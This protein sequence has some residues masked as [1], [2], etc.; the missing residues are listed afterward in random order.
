MRNTLLTTTALVLSAGIASA[1]GHASITWSGTGTAGLAREGS[2]AAVKLGVAKIGTDAQANKTVALGGAALTA[3]ASEVTDDATWAAMVL[4]DVA[5]DVDD[6]EDAM[7]TQGIA[8]TGH[9]GTTAAGIR[10]DITTLESAYALS[11]DATAAE[12]VI[13][14]TEVAALRGVL[15]TVFG[16]DAVAKATAGDFKTYSEVNST[17]T[18]SVTAGGMTMSASMSV[19]AGRGY[20][21]DASA[22]KGFDAAKTNGVSL[23]SVSLDMGAGGVI[24]FDDDN[25]AHLVDGDDDGTGDV[26][27]TNT[28]G[29]IT[30]SGVMDVNTKDTDAAYVAAAASTL[31]H[32]V[33]D[34]TGL[35]NTSVFVAATAATVQD[36]HWSAKV[37]VPL[38]N[39]TATVAMDEE[40]GNSFGASATVGGFGL[41]FDSALEAPDKEAKKARSNTVKVTYVMGALS[42]NASWNSVEDKDQWGIGATYAADGTSITASTDEGSDWAIS[43]SYLLG[44][45]ASVVGGVNYTE[46]A[47]LG[48]SFAF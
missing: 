11:V 44:S 27:Y 19:D 1:D 4:L 34:V 13:I 17:V 31:T 33:N 42:T 46:D 23:D 28:F 3:A 36:V 24:K 9:S 2:A 12:R 10:T 41:S 6:L 14:A 18:G 45:G 16:T 47:Y 8:V 30:F 37:S 29:A 48:L 25:I 35:A 40:G 20:T 15:D 26:S 43:G 7:V 21:F 5:L 39:G 38:G 22:T 32:T